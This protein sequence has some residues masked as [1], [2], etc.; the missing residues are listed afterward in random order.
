[1][2]FCKYKKEKNSGRKI[3][4]KNRESVL[5]TFYVMTKPFKLLIWKTKMFSMNNKQNQ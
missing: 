1:M 5:K 4:L 2:I 3:M